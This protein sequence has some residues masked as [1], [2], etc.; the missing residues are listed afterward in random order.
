MQTYDNAKSS[1]LQQESG[2]PSV[3]MINSKEEQ[4]FVEEL[5]FDDNK[6]VEN[7]WLGAKRDAKTKTFHWDDINNSNFTYSNLG[8]IKNSSDYECIEMIPIGKEKGKWTNTSCKKKNIVV[9]Q[10]MQDWTLARLQKEFFD[11]K[12]QFQKEKNQTQNEISKLK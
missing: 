9:C 12:K 1:C 6:I 4:Q 11:L 8:E 2:N 7:I 3:I 10:K 5:V